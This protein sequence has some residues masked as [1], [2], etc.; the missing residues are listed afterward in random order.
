MMTDEQAETLL[1]Q[2][3]SLTI[4]EIIQDVEEDKRLTLLTSL[5]Q[6]AIMKHKISSFLKLLSY[7]T[8][9]YANQP[10]PALD[11]SLIDFFR[12]KHTLKTYDSLFE[13][14]PKSKHI[15]LMNRLG[16]EL[17]DES[18]TYLQPFLQQKHQK[19]LIHSLFLS[20]AS[21][22]PLF[23]Y[24][25][26]LS[27]SE[28][29]ELLA[30]LKAQD[31]K[32]N[33]HHKYNALY[34]ELIKRHHNNRE[35]I[36]AL[37]QSEHAQGLLNVFLITP[38]SHPEPSH[39]LNDCLSH[40]S[41][42]TRNHKLLNDLEDYIAEKLPSQ[43]ESI[44]KRLLSSYQEAMGDDIFYGY[45]CRIIKSSPD[46]IKKLSPFLLENE[47][48][49]I[50]HFLSLDPP[51]DKKF[52]Q[53]LFANLNHTQ[54]S[55]LA[56][57]ANTPR[58]LD[59]P[60]ITMRA[61]TYI[62]EQAAQ[63]DEYP[64]SEVI[65][66]LNALPTTTFSQLINTLFSKHTSKIQSASLIFSLLSRIE[67]FDEKQTLILDY[68]KTALITIVT[69][70][71]HSSL[72]LRNIFTLNFKQHDNPYRSLFDLYLEK[73]GEKRYFKL[74]S[75]L[76]MLLPPDAINAPLTV[77]Y[78]NPSLCAALL[79]SSELPSKI[80]ENVVSHLN[81]DDFI[82]LYKLLS[83]LLS[84]NKS[85]PNNL[86]VLIRC[87]AYRINH[88]SDKI[89][90]SDKLESW[91]TN[92]P[93]IVVE[94]MSD[95]ICFTE[96]TK[97]DLSIIDTYLSKHY[98]AIEKRG[99]LL[100][101]STMHL[102][103]SD[104]TQLNCLIRRMAQHLLIENQS[105]PKRLM[106]S[107]YS[108]EQASKHDS[109]KDLAPFLDK[110]KHALFEILEH[111]KIDFSDKQ[112]H[113]YLSQLSTT[114][115]DLKRVYQSIAADAAKETNFQIAAQ[116]LEKLDADLT[117][118]KPSD[119]NILQIPE[120]LKQ[121]DPSSPNWSLFEAM[122]AK[123]EYSAL[124]PAL[125]LA[126]KTQLDSEDVT[127]DK[128]SKIAQF[129]LNHLYEPSQLTSE[130]IN[131]FNS[132]IPFI[133]A[134]FV[135]EGQSHLFFHELLR[136]CQDI[137]DINVVQIIALLSKCLTHH[138]L[139]ETKNINPLLNHPKLSNE[140]ALAI[141]FATFTGMQDNQAYLKWINEFYG[142]Q[143]PDFQ[144]A[145]LRLAIQTKDYDTP[146]ALSLL[147]NQFC[148]LDRLNRFTDDYSTLV[149]PLL[150]QLSTFCLRALSSQQESDLS[151]HFSLTHTLFK[152][153]LDINV[154]WCREIFDN[155][156]CLQL[157]E[158]LLVKSQ[159][160]ASQYHEQFLSLITDLPAH[161]TEALLSH[162]NDESMK[163]DV[164]ALIEHLLTHDEHAST[165][166]KDHYEALF[167]L[168]PQAR[169]KYVSK[170]LLERELISDWQ[171]PYRFMLSDQL[172]PTSLFDIFES[173]HQHP[174]Y[175]HLILHHPKSYEEL[176]EEALQSVLL[177]VNVNTEIDKL[178]QTLS[179]VLIPSLSYAILNH[180]ALPDF[181]KWYASVNLYDDTF[182]RFLNGITNKSDQ[183]HL[184]R[185][186]N[187][188]GY[189]DAQSHYVNKINHALSQFQG[190]YTIIN[191]G[192]LHEYLKH[193]ISSP[194]NLN[195]CSSKSRYHLIDNLDIDHITQMLADNETF[196]DNTLALKELM[197][198]F[199]AAFPVDDLN[200]ASFIISHHP[201]YLATAKWFLT[202][203]L[204]VEGHITEATQMSTIHSLLPKSEEV[205]APISHW[206]IRY[207][208]FLGA[209]FSH[210]TIIQKH[211]NHHVERIEN[212][213]DLLSE[214][215][216]LLQKENSALFSKLM[217]YLDE[218]KLHLMKALDKH[219]E[220]HHVIQNA[221]ENLAALFSIDSHL[222]K[223]TK[224][225]YVSD[226]PK[227]SELFWINV[228]QDGK[229]HLNN[230]YEAYSSG[231]LKA[232][233]S[234]FDICIRTDE[235]NPTQKAF[236]QMAL[237]SS[238]VVTDE[239]RIQ[240]ACQILDPEDLKDILTHYELT[241]S[242][243]QSTAPFFDA[244]Y[245]YALEHFDVKN[246]V[247]F[248]YSK[249]FTPAILDKMAALSKQ[250]HSLALSNCIEFVSQA[251]KS[252]LSLQ[253]AIPYLLPSLVSEHSEDNWLFPGL[254][255]VL[256]L[257]NK[258]HETYQTIYQHA[259]SYKP[260]KSPEHARKTLNHLGG[261]AHQAMTG[262]NLAFL[263]NS[264]APATHRVDGHS[265]VD[266]QYLQNAL[267]RLTQS[268]EY[269]KQIIL[270]SHLDVNL[271]RDLLLASVEDLSS[272]DFRIRQQ[273]ASL[274]DS[275]TAYGLR[276]E[277]NS[278]LKQTIRLV[279]SQDHFNRYTDI[280]SPI[281]DDLIQKKE[282][283]LVATSPNSEHL[284]KATV[285]GIWIQ[286][287]ITSPKVVARL[288]PEQLKEL[289]ER[290][291]RISQFLKTDEY[292]VYQTWEDKARQYL[293][294]LRITVTNQEAHLE[295][296][297]QRFK[298]QFK[299]TKSEYD[300]LRKTEAL[301]DNAKQKISRIEDKKRRILKFKAN[302]SIRGLLQ[303]LQLDIETIQSNDLAL[304]TK[305]QAILS[306][307]FKL[308]LQEYKATSLSKMFNFIHDTL[309]HDGDMAKQTSILSRLAEKYIPH[310]NFTT[311]ELL[312]KL[313]IDPMREG[314][315][316]FNEHE[317][318]IARLDENNLLVSDILSTNEDT[319][320][321]EPELLIKT[322]KGQ[323]GMRLYN[324]DKELVGFLRS[325]GKYS[326]DNLFIA[327][328]SLELLSYTPL[329]ELNRITLL[330][331]HLI[332][333]VIKEQQIGQ[334]YDKLFS[335]LD[336]T[337]NN[338]TKQQWVVGT[339]QTELVGSPVSLDKESAKRIVKYHSEAQYN[340]LLSHYLK[341][342]R[343]SAL[344]LIE[345]YLGN[346]DKAKAILHSDKNKNIL[347][348]HFDSLRLSGT[349]ILNFSSS[350]HFP[351]ALSNEIRSLLKLYQ[352]RKLDSVNL[353][354]DSRLS[355]KILTLSEYD[356]KSAFHDTVNTLE[357][358]LLSTDMAKSL[359]HD[360][361]IE[362]LLTPVHYAKISQ[363]N[364]N[365][366]FSGLTQTEIE[367]IYRYFLT[368]HDNRLFFEKGIILFLNRDPLLFYQVL[369]EHPKKD[370]IAE[371]LLT[372][373]ALT[374][375]VFQT[376]PQKERLILSDD[377]PLS[378]VFSSKKLPFYDLFSKNSF[379]SGIHAYVN[380]Y[381]KS[382]EL[383]C[384][385][386]NILSAKLET[387]L[388]TQLSA[389]DIKAL[390][391][392]VDDP[393][394]AT[395]HQRFPLY[396]DLFS[397]LVETA[398]KSSVTSLFYTPSQA[399]DFSFAKRKIKCSLLSDVYAHI[400]ETSFKDTSW[401]VLRHLSWESISQRTKSFINRLPWI[402]NDSGETVTW[403]EIKSTSLE[404]LQNMGGEVKTIDLYLLNYQGDVDK[405]KTL[406][407]DYCHSYY[408]EGSA[409][410]PDHTQ[411]GHLHSTT[412]LLHNEHI[413]STVKAAL[414]DVLQSHPRLRD[415][416][417][418]EEMAHYNITAVLKYYGKRKQ[419]DDIITLYQSNTR[420]RAEFPALKKAH[421]EAILEK[422]LQSLTGHAWIVSIKTWWARVWQ[423]N[424]HGFFIP[425]Q[426]HY[427]A[428]HSQSLNGL[429]L[430][431]KPKTE[432]KPILTLMTKHT[433]DV[434]LGRISSVLSEIQNTNTPFPLDDALL[435]LDEV[436]AYQPSYQ[437]PIEAE[438][439]IRKAI[440]DL[441]LAIIQYKSAYSNESILPLSTIKE[442]APN[443]RKQ[444]I[445]LY[446]YTKSQ[447][448]G[449]CDTE[450]GAL[451]K[452][453]RDDPERSRVNRQ[454]LSD[455]P[456]SSVAIK[457][458]NREEA[459]ESLAM[460][461]V[462]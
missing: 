25:P 97:T 110:L 129:I 354:G 168:L 364:F 83:E 398:A 146:A 29:T 246:I 149:N 352:L 340:A 100:I 109:G 211:T 255:Q 52:T 277:I 290:Y 310:C 96:L 128:K 194:L 184:K 333:D 195:K 12:Q 53:K 269:E 396:R 424:W 397:Q 206:L 26:S 312:R 309:T 461:M 228:L 182:I 203:P 371:K 258:Q 238:H 86:S 314:T 1:S 48:H 375:A 81:D 87:L 231:I 388:K 9:H 66:N 283:P 336:N 14:Y 449:E 79:F 20:D 11:D 8:K 111:D 459:Q 453:C 311:R 401:N 74:L 118:L 334:L 265:R 285:D 386:A 430:D 390:S 383:A 27:I 212:L 170:K 275:V 21:L 378:R 32:G 98:N 103:K 287:I 249:R 185:L 77:F 451:L 395:L 298:S 297:K 70:E 437:T 2:L 68:V 406:L 121:C 4:Q 288:T 262:K 305:S 84:T 201:V 439:K 28:L 276:D 215:I 220:Q 115:S 90:F 35:E 432:T 36:N 91:L 37:F 180:L 335:P 126:F 140:H 405:L 226:F 229:E 274:I 257:I 452:I 360:V 24:L 93:N 446:H 350:A 141:L 323:V 122:M 407:N 189:L 16:N 404:A 213:I 421:D 54:L 193:F 299:L 359:H 158:H 13:N 59:C 124:K 169:K 372:N 63:S 133:P 236:V 308:E 38:N 320:E 44:N 75:H 138:P 233:E 46:L 448:H 433:S 80:I 69:S 18:L 300:E 279:L 219:T 41:L 286:R 218:R 225:L 119:W 57:R 346:A 355:D 186:M 40:A 153:L 319:I 190:D 273:A 427:V 230:V 144:K 339:V 271:L 374:N 135:R 191:D 331:P 15:A 345:A 282:A 353:L 71:S 161:F 357:S 112:L 183:Q 318:L 429:N 67:D 413:S 45:L 50:I 306:Q 172:A 363:D 116:Q 330:T 92:A 237:L 61:F 450:I 419:Y 348:Q 210:Q 227:S 64:I 393:N 447:I 327:K 150:S 108:L 420:L 240:K 117:Y 412:R 296:Q 384:I 267:Y 280:I 367:N 325:D 10:I 164:Y 19:K 88:A 361:K 441:Y 317:E 65:A 316:I 42:N 410:L 107:L 379:M 338:K 243:A 455:Y 200:E 188:K 114:Y 261:L 425:N 293:A 175:A 259:L 163:H 179:P 106:D 399:L 142:Q 442:I 156:E 244:L 33:Q 443:N 251:K 431:P 321:D 204:I 456:I 134:N 349:D 155:P 291:R 268:C 278:E 166:P 260:H 385:L 178:Y 418:T 347:F 221:S 187:Q 281:I 131:V 435:L 440:H 426:P 256:S 423:Y 370:P 136:D 365:A 104:A 209:H 272:A 326:P 89:D 22:L 329:H 72:N 157:F 34:Q 294:E 428:Y 304:A 159:E 307:Y 394:F 123:S 303:K 264:Y 3:E 253:K 343:E 381:N 337:Q 373:P 454:I 60:T 17:T 403:Q 95:P 460:S 198:P 250:A 143:S 377:M 224:D 344:H 30:N 248:L 85:H 23:D 232:I 196:L 5:V 391:S 94:L 417:I 152:K 292:N 49:K 436:K 387:F 162:I 58:T 328:T 132:L 130:Q 313:M 382:K 43:S 76:L 62:A 295:R 207:K 458:G 6:T 358:N 457:Q 73:A 411:L 422:Q 101:R 368:H 51:I 181:H 438:I 174:L 356:Y 245:D 99:A 263:L 252:Q 173:H 239:K 78:Q 137:P 234:S 192:L 392:L 82:A 400:S 241:S 341:H 332:Q 216:D 444:L 254:S 369:K 167:R 242:I 145:Y 351:H 113:S 366:L 202:L 208:Q 217:F 56:L 414:F 125:I 176:S 322:P 380:G 199:Q 148:Q 434:P 416:R 284:T 47:P 266:I 139:L 342:N 214:G 39:F 154:A 389:K 301:I 177:S 205:P 247:A 223:I 222:A 55:M 324:A 235:V 7:I 160:A 197:S 315:L 445:E 409:K 165:L 289:I 376:L 270:F 408:I 127:D 171:H 151:V 31:E 147:L 362:I 105:N 302:D 415:R 102:F 462:Y 402:N 120:I